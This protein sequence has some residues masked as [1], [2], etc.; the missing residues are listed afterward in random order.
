MSNLSGETLSQIVGL[1]GGLDAQQSIALQG[2]GNN[3]KSHKRHKE[4]RS[5]ERCLE[6]GQGKEAGHECMESVQCSSSQLP[7]VLRFPHQ[8]RRRDAAETSEACHDE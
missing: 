8:D 2:P 3:W 5:L 7:M 1:L 6:N 4:R